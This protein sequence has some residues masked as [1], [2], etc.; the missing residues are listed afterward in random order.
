MTRRTRPDGP[1]RFPSMTMNTGPSPTPPLLVVGCPRSGTSLFAKLLDAAGLTTVADERASDKYPS[2]YFEHVPLLMFH[3]AMERFPRE[4][5]HHRADFVPTTDPF[6]EAAHLQQPF[7][8]SLFA[9]AFAPILSGK[10]DFLK[11]PQLALSLDALFETLGDVRVVAVWRDPTRAVLSLARK[12]FGRD[13]FPF[14]GLR[15]VLLWTTYAYHICRAKER[16][17][18]RVAVA[19]VDRVVDGSTPVD[20]VLKPLGYDI[21]AVPVSDVV[22]PHVWT[23]ESSLADR[24]RVHALDRLVS[25]SARPLGVDPV[26]TGIDAW[27]RRLLAVTPA[28]L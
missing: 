2:G 12:E 21:T 19:L 16:H 9:E 18:D 27:T 17:P 24:L 8:E 20:R 25:A 15:S 10:V 28:T 7:V 26:L 23:K 14:R 4:A 11:F 6:L 13:V 3:K 1:H 5:T 22:D